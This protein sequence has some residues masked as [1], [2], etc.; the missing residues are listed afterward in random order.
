MVAKY[1]GIMPWKF[2][3][4]TSEQQAEL[5]A[6]HDVDKKIEGFYSDHA[7]REKKDDVG[8]SHK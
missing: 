4:L 7:L 3:S 8:F 6:V 5:T 2:R 1:W